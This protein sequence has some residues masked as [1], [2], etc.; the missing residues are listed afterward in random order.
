[1]AAELLDLARSQAEGVV[2]FVAHTL[3]RESASTAILRRLGFRL[4]EGE[5]AHPEDGTVWK[6]RSLE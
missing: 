2:A 3:P 6:W 5:F 4:L 1:M